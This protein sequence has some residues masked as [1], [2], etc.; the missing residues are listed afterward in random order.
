MPEEDSSTLTLTDPTIRSFNGLGSASWNLRFWETDIFW[1]ILSGMGIGGASVARSSAGRNLGKTAPVAYS[2]FA[3]DSGSPSGGAD[4][5][6]C[7]LCFAFE[8]ACSLS[9]AA[10]CLRTALAATSCL[11]LIKIFIYIDIYR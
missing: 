2:G 8:T 1:M 4:F 7:F 11:H 6:A 9:R 3:I 10:R 5:G